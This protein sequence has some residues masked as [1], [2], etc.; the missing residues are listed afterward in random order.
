MLRCPI[1]AC[2]PRLVDAS[3]PL[4]EHH[5]LVRS[6]WI[7]TTEAGCLCQC[8]IDV[9]PWHPRGR[10]GRLV[11]T[12]TSIA[13]LFGPMVQSGASAS[14]FFIATQQLGGRDRLNRTGIVA[15]CA[16]S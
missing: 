7:H 6:E 12:Y 1:L 9:P 13:R 16:T 15:P 11:R 5:P 14:K 8:R 3:Y 4:R 2:C 10:G